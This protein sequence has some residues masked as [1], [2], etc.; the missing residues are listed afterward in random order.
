MIRAAHEPTLP[1]PWTTTRVSDGREPERRRGLAEAEHDAA[2]GRRLA[3]ERSAERDRLAGDD[4]R[5]V[6]VELAVLVHHPGH[7]LGVRVDVGRGDVARRPEHLLDLVDERPR[8]ALRARR[9]L[10][11]VRVAVDAALRAAERDADDRGLPRHERGERAHLV[12][13]DLRVVADA[14]LVRPARARCAGRGSRSRRGSARRPGG[15]GSGPGPRGSWTAGPRARR[16][17]ARAGRRRARSSGRRSR[18]SRPPPHASAAPGS[19]PAATCRCPT[20]WPCPP[21]LRFPRFRPSRD[22]PTRLPRAGPSR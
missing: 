11:C 1:K 13:V 2:P 10:S 14:A 22:Y 20:S 12:E 17:R 4:R 15:S 21:H 19:R 8:D 5:R 16:P 9:R 7:H 3:P 18:S 6:A